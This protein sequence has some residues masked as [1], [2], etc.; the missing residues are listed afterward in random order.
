MSLWKNGTSGNW[1]I[2]DLQLFWWYARSTTG[3]YSEM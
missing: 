3:G 2:D 1:D